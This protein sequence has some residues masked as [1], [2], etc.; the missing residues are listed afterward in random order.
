MEV[1]KVSPNVENLAFPRG[2]L[3]FAPINASG[4]M[5]GEI[6][7]GNCASFD[8]T[9]G[10]GF[11]EHMT[12]HDNIVVMDAKKP[13]EQKWTAKVV[14][15][16]RS[17]E[18]MALFLLGDPDA[19]KT[20]GTG[21]LVQ[22]GVSVVAE[23]VKI[24]YDR[25]TSLA[26]RLVKADSI[27]WDIMGDTFA[28]LLATGEIRVDYEN[29]MFMVL[30]DSAALDTDGGEVDMSYICGTATLKKFTTRTK[31]IQ[32][33]L[34]YR[35]TS[36]VGPRHA[37]ECWKAQIAPDAAMNFIKPTDFAVGGFTFDLF[38]DSAAG[39]HPD[40]PFF[41]IIELAPATSYPLS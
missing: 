2:R 23:T 10:I 38:I 22:A 17:A 36:E 7:L 34:R 1:S 27:S 9:N 30:S 8:L 32:G 4:I 19:N 12:S 15:E 21:H 31:A 14:P 35:G 28:S 29:G 41:R 20:G 16:E 6:D 39:A 26:N 3:S 33:F 24:Y 18:N 37:I 5:T 40:D 11:K 13:T 25:W